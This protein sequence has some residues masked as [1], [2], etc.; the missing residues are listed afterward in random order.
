LPEKPKADQYLN[1]FKYRQYLRIE[2]SSFGWDWGPAFAPQGIWKDVY[3]VSV[4]YVAILYVSPHIFVCKRGTTPSPLTDDNNC[5]DVR[6]DVWLQS[7]AKQTC[8][9]KYSPNWMARS[10]KTFDLE[11]GENLATMW[12]KA[13]NV[14]LWWPNGYGDQILYVIEVEVDCGTMNSVKSELVNIGFRSVELITTYDDN[15]AMFFRINGVPIFSKGA[16]WIPEDAFESRVTPETAKDLLQSAVDAN[17]NMVRVWGGGIYQFEDFYSTCDKLGLMVWQ[18]MIF[19][20]AQYPIDDPF[21]DNV[22]EEIKHQIRRLTRHPSIVMWSGN[23]ENGNPYDKG[24]NSPYEILNFGVVL[25]Q[26]CR[27]DVSRPVWNSSPSQ[28]FFSGTTESGL[29]SGTRE[30]PDKLMVGG[31]SH[32]EHHYNYDEC[33]NLLSFPNSTQFASEYGFQSLPSFETIQPVTIEEDWFLFSK[34]MQARQHHDGGNKQIQSLLES[35]FR[36]PDFN[37]NSLPIFQRIIYL[38]QVLQSLCI[39]TETEYYRRARYL[40]QNVMGTLYWQLNQNWQAPS[41]TSLEY[42]G[43]W[44]I[45]HYQAREM[46]SPTLISSHTDTDGIGLQD[47]YIVKIM[48]DYATPITGTVKVDVIHWAGSMKTVNF[49]FHLDSMGSF[50]WKISASDLLKAGNCAQAKD[51]FVRLTAVDG[52]GKLVAPVNYYWL[53]HL[54]DIDLKPASITT[55]IVKYDEANKVVTVTISSD[56][57]APWVTIWSPVNGIWTENVL[58]LLPNTP[59]ETTFNSKESLPSQAEFQQKLRIDYLNAFWK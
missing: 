41:W 11:A 18:E 20:C 2:Q 33:T 59:V 46:Y 10:N 49:D 4:A 35:N 51:C 15:P 37:N 47:N 40:T 26:V 42:G 43:R 32:D 53:T 12:L 13:E 9:I 39:R 16:N 45:F 24:P 19:A 14:N 22:R 6:V 57:V 21:L 55:S 44:K 23:N 25:D 31:H 58:V 8:D 34:W 52:S 38:T 7:D 1:G 17:M 50:D 3:L 48:T 29:P 5:F 28:N 27:E 30:K 36:T 54:K 56:T